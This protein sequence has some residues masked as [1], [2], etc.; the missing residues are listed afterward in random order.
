[1]NK[2]IW[3]VANANKGNNIKIKTKEN[4]KGVRKIVS[5]EICFTCREIKL[6]DDKS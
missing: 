1:M 4:L 2:E 6:T 5:L 3:Y